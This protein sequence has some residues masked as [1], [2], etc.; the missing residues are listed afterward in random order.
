VNNTYSLQEV[1]GDLQRKISKSFMTGAVGVFSSV[2]SHGLP[3][4]NY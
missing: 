4:Q 3:Y 2:F 1:K